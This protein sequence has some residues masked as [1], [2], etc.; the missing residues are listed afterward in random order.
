MKTTFKVKKPKVIKLW[1]ILGVRMQKSDFITYKNLCEKNGHT[2]SE[3]PKQAI[4]NYLNNHAPKSEP[5]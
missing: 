1:H 2:I 3:I 5:K 4:K